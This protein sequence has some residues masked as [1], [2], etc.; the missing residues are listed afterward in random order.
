MHHNVNHRRHTTP[1]LKQSDKNG[2]ATGALA[3]VT[4]ARFCDNDTDHDGTNDGHRLR[5]RRVLVRTSPWA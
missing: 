5:R 3:N 2:T 4:Q 1:T